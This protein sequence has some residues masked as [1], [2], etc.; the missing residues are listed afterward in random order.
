MNPFR[1]ATQLELSGADLQSHIRRCLLQ[2]R[3]DI[4]GIILFGS[5]ARGEQW[6]DID[7][8]VIVEQLGSASGDWVE[9]AVALSSAVALPRLEIVPYSRQGFENG[10][11]NHTPFLL[12]IAVDG[13]L[14]YDRDNVH[15]LLEQTRQYIQQRGIRRTR[16]GGWQFPVRFR[17]STAL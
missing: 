4:V 5:Y 2:V 15:Q 7:C 16:T 12:D 1:P 8:L 13:E 3:D 11:G 14:L 6:R 9:T 10:L 17:E